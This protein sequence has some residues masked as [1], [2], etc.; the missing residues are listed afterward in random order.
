MVASSLQVPEADVDRVVDTARRVAIQP[1]VVR[2]GDILILEGGKHLAIA[3]DAFRAITVSEAKIVEE[4][5]TPW[6]DVTGV[7]RPH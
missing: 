6:S 1:S 4:I 2:P 3:L 5:L 7:R